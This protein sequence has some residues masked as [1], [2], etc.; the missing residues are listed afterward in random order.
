MTAT[1]DQITDASAHACAPSS[2]EFAA[3]PAPGAELAG[4]RFAGVT[5][6]KEGLHCAVVLLPEQASDITWREAKEWAASLGGQLPTRPAAAL[7]YALCKPL[8]RPKWHWTC[9]EDEDD[10]SSA[11]IC[12][13]SYGLQGGSLKGCRGSAVAVRLIPI[14]S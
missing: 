6:T 12:T 5:T 13:F 1:T 4:G 7:L 9:E 10:A 11:W 8:L 2:L 14:A 3:L